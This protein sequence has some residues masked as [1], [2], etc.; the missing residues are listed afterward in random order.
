ML[1]LLED[2]IAGPGWMARA[3]PAHDFLS[4]TAGSD[5]ASVTAAAA[6]AA[7]ASVESLSS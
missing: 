4:L 7:A 5:D 3:R 2:D 6:V 1:A